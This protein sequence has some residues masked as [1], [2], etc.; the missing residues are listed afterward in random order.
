MNKIEFIKIVAGTYEVLIN[1]ESYIFI[2]KRGN[3]WNT[4]NDS[5]ATLKEAKEKIIE[6]NR[7]QSD[8]PLYR[9][10][11]LLGSLCSPFRPIQTIYH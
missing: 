9:L 7:C 6:S 5:Y 1:G 10:Q 8:C 3:E 11:A 4:P 2:T